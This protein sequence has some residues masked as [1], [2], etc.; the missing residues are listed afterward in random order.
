MILWAQCR[1]IKYTRRIRA[2]GTSESNR[3]EVCQRVSRRTNISNYSKRENNNKT[4]TLNNKIHSSTT[5]AKEEDIVEHLKDLIARLMQHGDDGEAQICHFPQTRHHFL[6]W[7][8]VQSTSGFW[9][10]VNINEIDENILPSRNMTVGSATSSIP[11]FTRFRCP[12]DILFNF[13]FHQQGQK[14]SR[15][16]T[17]LNRRMKNTRV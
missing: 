6:R 7:C 12:P 10:Q 11:M 16:K 8:A 5:F 9:K 14:Y 4:Q 15:K 3:L 17:S 13:N 2:R 1:G